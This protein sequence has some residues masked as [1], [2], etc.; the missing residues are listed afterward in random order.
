MPESIPG[1][2][3]QQ[4]VDIGPAAAVNCPCATSATDGGLGSH[5]DAGGHPGH[6]AEHDRDGT[7]TFGDNAPPKAPLLPLRSAEHP[8]PVPAHRTCLSAAE[9]PRLS[10]RGPRRP[11][12]QRAFPRPGRGQL[13]DDPLP[14]HLDRMGGFRAAATSPAPPGPCSWKSSRMLITSHLLRLH[15]CS[16]VTGAS[17]A[18]AAWFPVRQRLSPTIGVHPRLLGTALLARGPPGMGRFT[19]PPPAHTPPATASALE[20]CSA[21]L[22]QARKEDRPPGRLPS[23]AGPGVIAALPLPPRLRR[24]APG[25]H[26]P[27]VPLHD[28]GVGHR[29]AEAGDE[30]TVG[31]SHQGLP[32][33]PHA[34]AVVRIPSPHV[35]Q[36][37]LCELG[38][39]S[40]DGGHRQRPVAVRLR[41]R[42]RRRA[43]NRRYRM[44][45]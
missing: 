4:S 8:V 45:G 24:T 17:P 16:P 35:D 39:S 20:H 7:H 22:A 2:E 44:M 37:Q 21:G 28:Q 43:R 25:E 29:N 15:G 23:S 18:W 42:G 36:Q 34:G 41:H 14:D 26:V 32:A 12:P 6:E 31:R 40:R 1:F 33:H 27:A 38:V 13:F 30:T 3:G 10:A 19:L 9:G 11:L 5:A